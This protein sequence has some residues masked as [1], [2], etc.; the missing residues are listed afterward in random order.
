MYYFTFNPLLQCEGKLGPRAASFVCRLAAG[1]QPGV[2]CFPLLT[3]DG[4]AAAGGQRVVCFPLLR[5]DG[6]AAPGDTLRLVG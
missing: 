1:G 2:G 4:G 6:G 3:L 5:L